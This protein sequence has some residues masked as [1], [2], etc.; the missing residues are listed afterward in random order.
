[1]AGT[2]KLFLL[3]NFSEFYE[4]EFN[5]TDTLNSTFTVDE[6]TIACKAF[7]LPLAYNIAV[8]ILYV[9]IFLLAIPGNI[10]VGLVIISNLRFLSPSDIYL[11][12]LV[13]AD[14]LMALTLP[15]SSI[16]ILTGWIFGGAM[17]K[18]VNLVREA[19]FYT[20][21]LFL[22]CISVDRYMVIVRAME[23]RK[24]QRIMCSWAVCIVVWILG[25]LLSLPALY[26]DVHSIDG[27]GLQICAERFEIDRADEWRLATRV[28]K[29]FLGFLIPL[30]VMLTCYGVTV[31]RLL[32]T[33]GFQ[34]QR[35]MKVIA[36]VMAAFLLCWT[37]FNLATM[38]DT[39]LRANLV[40]NGCA[41][42]HAVNL[43]MFITQSLALI[44]CC[45]NPVLYGFVGEKFR[46][47]LFHMIKKTRPFERGTPSRSTRSTSQTSE[48]VSRFL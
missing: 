37:P 9:H 10:T 26:N 36:A 24:V 35:A 40:E 29:H 6:T 12:H 43:A 42:Q 33:R 34:R 44:H 15:F 46:M 5:Y 32:R 41:A 11:F 13:I 22:V 4:E 17:C 14:T 8:C 48:G 38:V 25:V 30:C 3:G 2:N 18:L 28:M 16:D 39:L 47:R 23:A 1:M 20:S 21:I 7:S 19:N 45:V 31:A 27:S